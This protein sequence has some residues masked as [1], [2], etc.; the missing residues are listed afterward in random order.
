MGSG[1]MLMTMLLLSV[2]DF[3]FRK[4]V[5]LVGVGS[6]IALMVSEGF[7][8]CGERILLIMSRFHWMST[9]MLQLFVGSRSMGTILKPMMQ[10]L[11]TNR[12]MSALMMLE[13]ALLNMIITNIIS[14]DSSRW[15]LF[16]VI[17]LIRIVHFG[18]IFDC[19]IIVKV[20]FF[21]FVSVLFIGSELFGFLMKE[22]LL[23]FWLF[24]EML[25]FFMMFL[26]FLFMRFFN[27]NF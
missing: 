3:L 26:S 5:G 21:I 2:R 11:T 14:T 16:I 8:E 19:G 22:F 4:F 12:V 17:N 24:L 20:F 6:S 9:L 13:S 1:V 25:L 23:F 27:R 18:H 15:S 10:F 7:F